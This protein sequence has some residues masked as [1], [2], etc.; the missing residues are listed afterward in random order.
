MFAKARSFHLRSE[1]DGPQAPFKNWMACH[2]CWKTTPRHE[3]I[4]QLLA[5]ILTQGLTGHPGQTL[6]GFYASR[7]WG[8]YSTQSTYAEEPYLWHKSNSF[9]TEST[10]WRIPG[11]LWLLRAV[12]NFSSPCPQGVSVGLSADFAPIQMSTLWTCGLGPCGFQSYVLWRQL[13]FPPLCV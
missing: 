8:L 9:L 6:F 4:S 11:I 7:P 13:A 10:S 2:L 12:Q 1:T 5:G 3:V